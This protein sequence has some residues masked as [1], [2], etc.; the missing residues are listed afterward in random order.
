MELLDFNTLYSN[1]KPGQSHIRF[2]LNNTAT[3]A[4]YPILQGTNPH[5]Y[6]MLDFLFSD[7]RPANFVALDDIQSLQFRMRIADQGKFFTQN[8]PRVSTDLY[9]HTFFEY[10]W[11][12]AKFTFRD[13]THSNV[14]MNILV[15]RLTTNMNRLSGTH[16]RDW[17]S[18]PFLSW[19]KR[20]ENFTLR[21]P[22]G[23]CAYTKNRSM[24]DMLGFSIN[25]ITVHTV[26]Y[27][28]TDYFIVMNSS[29]ETQFY[30]GCHIDPD[31][32][33]GT[34]L[35][36]LATRYTEL[37][38]SLEEE[39]KKPNFKRAYDM[40]FNFFPQDEFCVYSHIVTPQQKLSKIGT[41][42]EVINEALT[43]L[44]LAQRLPTNILSVK[45]DPTKPD[46]ILVSANP[47][48]RHLKLAISLYVAVTP[49]NSPV[50]NYFNPKFTGTSNLFNPMNN[51]F[52][53]FY[54]NTHNMKLE[55]V[56]KFEGEF[57]TP[58]F[59]D[60]TQDLKRFKD[61]MAVILLNVDPSLN[62]PSRIG[63]NLY[64]IIGYISE[65]GSFRVAKP[66]KI[67]FQH[68]HLE[69]GL[70]SLK[71]QELHEFSDSTNILMILQTTQ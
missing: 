47:N 16:F 36:W 18:C 53:C 28:A 64:Y 2:K 35:K 51:I 22:P 34:V 61:P 26:T 29:Q 57:E 58:N 6:N 1:I 30:N 63:D 43:E 39:S 67:P 7:H 10:P 45:V 14:T 70:L 49:T 9:K 37:G 5:R 68:S 8:L 66:F 11:L 62:T 71:S 40:C 50:K 33:E 15:S 44:F 20:D 59:K 48:M 17:N 23:T 25:N 32:M 55:S 13:P 24:W 3:A 19:F 38:T 46:R 54:G 69:V 56:F 4:N 21:L 52:P 65:E 12:F 31:H 42:I 27:K 60:L 41:A